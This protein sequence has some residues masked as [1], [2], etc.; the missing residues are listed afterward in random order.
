MNI[1]IVAGVAVGAFLLSLMLGKKRK[2]AADK[3][4]ILYLIFF[5]ASQAYFYLEAQGTFQHTAW[6]LLGRGL[7]LL[8]GPLFFYYVYTL[9]TSK[10]ISTR[11]YVFTLLPFVLYSVHFFYYYLAIFPHHDVHIENGLLYIEGRLPVTWTIF[12]ILLVISDPFYLAWFYRLLKKYRHQ[13]VQSVSN[14]DLINLNWL[15][16]VFYLWA[17]S[18]LI[19]VPVLVFSIGRNWFSSAWVATLMQVDYLCFIF[20]LGYYGFRQ[21]AVFSA[22][23]EKADKPE[24][25][26]QAPY[27][28]SGLTADQAAVYHRKLLVLM[29]DQQP[30]LEGEL[31]AQQLA[32][33]LD[34]SP[35]HLS[36]VI[37]Q[38]EGK[39]FFDFINQY[40]VDEVK[41]K[42]ANDRYRSFTLL[43]I[44]LESGFNSKTSFNTV[45]K[46]LTGLTPSQYYKS[47]S[48]Q[49]KST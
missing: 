35:N 2:L 4:L 30:Y 1:I 43:A 40:R 49:G 39:N 47:Q 29:K 23:T 10:Q 17:L 25:K 48:G 36:Q 32:Q 34:I 9:T 41:R 7:H 11:V 13:S 15:N 14:L 18:M 37:N 20:L 8:G 24:E 6:M 42:M 38:R 21:S 44:A 27:E 5:I 3:F 19:F 22:P 12:V 28:R 33:Q 16:I 46:K 26:K 31:T 45:F